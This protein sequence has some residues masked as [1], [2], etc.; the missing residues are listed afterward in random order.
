LARHNELR[1]EHEERTT[2]TTGDTPAEDALAIASPT[3]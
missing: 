3:R 1:F 2:T